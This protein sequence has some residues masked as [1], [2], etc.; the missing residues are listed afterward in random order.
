MGQLLSKEQSRGHG[1]SSST[2]SR[3]LSS[4]RPSTQPS[5]NSKMA[6][7]ARHGSWGSE[8]CIS[9]NSLGNS[10]PEIQ[11]TLSRERRLKQVSLVWERGSESRQARVPTMRLIRACDG[12]QAEKVGVSAFVKLM[13]SKTRR[14][15]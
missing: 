8:S 4:Q 7:G 9:D 2:A 1:S 14:I 15:L 10:R 3:S 6:S 12:H 5:C 11:T 13:K